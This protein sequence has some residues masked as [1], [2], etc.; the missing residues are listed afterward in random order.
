MKVP[1]FVVVLTSLL[2]TAGAATPAGAQV[3][4]A[5]ES[6]TLSSNPVSLGAEY[7]HSVALSA[8][9]LAVGAWMDPTTGYQ[10][11][12]IHIYVD[13]GGT[14]TFQQKIVEPFQGSQY[15][16]GENLALQ[17][18][19]L[20]V[21]SSWD[22]Q[23]QYQSGA[24]RVYERVG[25]TWSQV[26]KLKGT[27]VAYNRN[28]GR[29]IAL[30]GDTI[31]AGASYECCATSPAGNA[32]VFRRVGG[33]WT[34]EAM[35]S[36][37]GTGASDA[38]G[39]AVAIDGDRLVVGQP[40]LG[41]AGGN[42]RGSVHVFTRSGS[43]WTQSQRIEGPST[44]SHHFFGQSVALA[45]STLVV[46]VPGTPAPGGTQSRSGRVDVFELV[47]GSF[48]P[49]ATLAAN[50]ASENDRFGESLALDA[51]VLVVG[52]PGY[53]Y[54]SGLGGAYV[55]ERN[56]GV[57]SLR[58]KLVSS[59]RSSG[60]ELG[61]SVA[62][63]GTDVAV[64]SPRSD[65]PV[66]DTGWALTYELPL[67]AVGTAFCLGDGTSGP[68]PCSNGTAAGL[69]LGC[70]NGLQRGAWVVATGSSSVAA[71]DL[72]FH[73]HGVRNTTCVL[74]ASASSSPSVPFGNGLSCLASPIALET[75]AASDASVHFGPG[76]GA[77]ALWSPGQ[78]WSFQIHHRD[79]ATSPCMTRKNTTSG[80]QVVITP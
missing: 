46:G 6:Q 33:T 50:D 59:I 71:N 36:G 10:H 2:F 41:Y 74:T 55:F 40:G 79:S 49:V 26:V 64:G 3:F 15:R 17:G 5:S 29:S 11:G 60:G 7:G 65:L 47:A 30:D 67:S 62:V 56:A 38:F 77:L 12:S 52:A 24:V 73:A 75:R 27:N 9:T 35:L 48:V 78:T 21:G 4:G 31:V 13:V 69:Q 61:T 70:K 45:G 32:Y 80:V 14:W 42:T 19:R 22:A 66:T 18:D 34:Q 8:G 44:G 43:T 1:S 63:D 53:E 28:L 57:W 58:T 54:A 16:L 51:D 37:V 39:H 72:A 68:C 76:Y 20:A 25:S 23:D